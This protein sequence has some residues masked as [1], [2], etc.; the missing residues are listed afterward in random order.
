MQLDQSE[1][2]QLFLHNSAGSH[3]AR[4]LQRNEAT[5]CEYGA[6]VMD[7]RSLAFVYMD[8]WKVY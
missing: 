7:G 6:V 8:A 2:N 3:L 5:E 4:F 1:K